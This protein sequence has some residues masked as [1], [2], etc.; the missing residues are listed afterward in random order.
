ME[1]THVK[2]YFSVVIGA[3]V[4]GAV[5]AGCNTAPVQSSGDT[6]PGSKSSSENHH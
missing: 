1:Y 5:L 6:Y 3:I 4:L 2:K